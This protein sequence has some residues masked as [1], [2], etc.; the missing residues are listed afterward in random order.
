MIAIT[1][2]G[3]VEA[4]A[5]SDGKLPTSGTGMGRIPR[6]DIDHGNTS[7]QGLVFDKLGKL[8]ERP[9]VDYLA[10]PLTHPV[11]L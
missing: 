2:G 3:T 8:S 10:A 11:S 1:T 9:G 4:M 5:I 7:L 6:V